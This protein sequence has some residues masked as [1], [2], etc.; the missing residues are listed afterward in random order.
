MDEILPDVVDVA[1]DRR[2]NDRPLRRTVGAFE[3]LLEVR[4]R[5]LHHLGRLQNER[6][7]QLAAAEPVADVLHRGQ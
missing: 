4:D 3:E 7:D 6:Q 5:L 1:E 2:E